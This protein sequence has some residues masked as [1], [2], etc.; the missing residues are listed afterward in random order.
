MKKGLV[1]K[2][3]RRVGAYPDD[4]FG[5]VTLAR[6]NTALDEL[7]RLRGSVGG[8]DGVGELGEEVARILE[9]QIGVKEVPRD[10]NRGKMVQEYQASTW[11]D[12]PSTGWPW[13]AAFICWGV[14]QAGEVIEL[15][16]KRPRT[17][18]AWDFERWAD[19]EGLDMVKNPSAKDIQR[20]DIIV[21]KF[22]HIGL[23][24]GPATSGGLVPT[25]EGNT[26]AAG[27][28]EGGGVWAKTRKVS[29]IRSRIR[30]G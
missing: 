13:C 3:Q 11:I 30:L 19:K 16:F 27:G 7:D 21:F 22:S 14:E 1:A 15:P 23:A 2:L 6:V 25:V 10:S 9:T 26:N 4:D 28:R 17:A 18:G 5:K 24:T 20:G 29:Q 8:S 12:N